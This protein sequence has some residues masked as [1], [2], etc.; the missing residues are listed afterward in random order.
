MMQHKIS[1]FPAHGDGTKLMLRLGAESPPQSN[2]ARA[3]VLK[4]FNFHR[5]G[6]R[7]RW[8]ILQAVGRDG[9]EF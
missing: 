4:L 7:R 3:R 9:G 6:E 1:A 8:A 5:V 2:K